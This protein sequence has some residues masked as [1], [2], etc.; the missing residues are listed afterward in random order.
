MSS[1]KVSLKDVIEQER[2]AAA[3]QPAGDVDFTVPVATVPLPSKGVVYPTS[4]PLFG[5]TSLDIKSMTAQEENILTSKALL[6]KGTVIT[7]LM[8]SCITNKLIDP[9]ELLVGDR[10]AIVYAIRIS[11]YGPEYLVQVECPVPDC[12]HREEVAFDL[13]RLPIKQMGVTPVAEGE[14]RF[15]FNLPMLKRPAYFKLM[16]GAMAH[17]LSRTLESSKKARGVG[18]A[19]EEVTT[20]LVMQVIQIGNETDPGKL[21]KMIRT[22]PARDSRELREYMDDVA[23]GID[24]YQSYTCSACETES[25]VDVPMG[26][27]FFWPASRKRR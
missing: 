19:E 26:P 1:E 18:A 27:E 6:R 13:S 23:P 5:V 4:S 24:M 21:A 17:E 22:M 3:S 25:E 8:R 20:R 14:N 15:V 16:T 2:L 12:G 7:Q 11:G 9:D 10:N